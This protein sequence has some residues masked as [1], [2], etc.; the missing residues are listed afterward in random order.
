M[1]GV[2]E[3]TNGSSQPIDKARPDLSRKDTR[4]LL[5]LALEKG[6]GPLQ[7]A[8]ELFIGGVGG[9]AK[10]AGQHPRLLARQFAELAEFGAARGKCVDGGRQAG[11]QRA[12]ECESTDRRDMIHRH[13]HPATADKGH[14]GQ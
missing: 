4:E 6:D 5:H 7:A 10:I 1:N 3:S 2:E 14:R 13:S 11:L 8:G 12:D 9:D